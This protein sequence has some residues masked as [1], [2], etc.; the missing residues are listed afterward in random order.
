MAAELVRLNCEDAGSGSKPES[1]R[2]VPLQPEY[3]KCKP[4]QPFPL[5]DMRQVM[6][7]L[8]VMLR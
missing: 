7:S 1:L 6:P 2:W 8:W 3:F 4:G 5:M